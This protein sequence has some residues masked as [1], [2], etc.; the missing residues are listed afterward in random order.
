M[1]VLN[2]VVHLLSQRH[3][4]VHLHTADHHWVA[5]RA[6]WSVDRLHPSELGHRL[7]ARVGSRV[8]NLLRPVR[9]PSVDRWLEPGEI[10]HG[11]EVV[12]TPGHTPGH[13]S[14]RFGRTILGGDAFMTG[15]PFREAVSFFIADRAESRRSIERLAGLDL[16]HAVSGH[17]PPAQDASKKLAAL[18]ATWAP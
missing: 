9:L 7:L 16:D 13:V 5:D 17:G 6:A 10:V 14:Y 12:P 1:R 4:A 2:D 3:G 11:L 18:A 8:A 15:E